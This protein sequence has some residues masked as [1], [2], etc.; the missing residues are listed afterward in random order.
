M[1][2]VELAGARS[3]V[4]ADGF[5]FETQPSIV[6]SPVRLGYCR[7]TLK[8][9]AKQDAT[10]RITNR[11]MNWSLGVSVAM[12]AG[13]TTAWLITGSAAIL[14]DAAESIIHVI[15]VAFAAFSL[16]LARRPASDRF[17]FGYEKIGFFSAG[18]EGAL[19][20]VAAIA[21]IVTATK[22]WISGLEIQQLGLGTMVVLA[23]SLVNLALGWYLVRVGR[24]E[25]NIILEANGKHVLSDSWTSFGVVAGLCLVLLTG[26]KPFDPICAIVVAFNLFWSGGKL[27]WRSIRGLLDYADPKVYARLN[28]KLEEI[29]RECGVEFHEIRFRSTGKR[30][31]G[32]VHLLFP[33]SMT[34][35]EAHRIATSIEDRLS[36]EFDQPIELSTHLESLEDHAAVHCNRRRSS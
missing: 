29:C 36:K 24:R 3:C 7:R 28:A 18:F 20:A 12:L 19:I 11:A 22:Q 5:D 31:L 1:G 34:I 32:A 26:W 17:L 14:S 6:K 16:R 30:I 2:C 33:S 27:V 15:A 8:K 9:V 25:H 10:D 23:A 21:I 4:R 35:G 13:K